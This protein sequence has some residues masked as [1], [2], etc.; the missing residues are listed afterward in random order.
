METIILNNNSGCPRVEDA[1]QKVHTATF[2][3]SF[4][5]NICVEKLVSLV[6]REQTSEC[7][8]VW[9]C[10]WVYRTHMHAVERGC[11]WCDVGEGVLESFQRLRW[12]L[13][14]CTHLLKPVL[15]RKVFSHWERTH[16]KFVLN[17]LQC[18][19]AQF[20]CEIEQSILTNII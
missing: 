12:Q 13:C 8:S 18:S 15:C 16:W 5:Q 14:T 19:Q 7:V 3:Y 10:S 2:I 1:W 4:S 6:E 17:A 11:H 20:A 9:E